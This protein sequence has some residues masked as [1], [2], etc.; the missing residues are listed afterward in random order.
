MSNRIKVTPEQIE[1]VGKQFEQGQNQSRQIVEGLTRSIEQMQS[2]WEGMTRERF[3]VQFQESRQQMSKFLECLHNVSTDLHQIATKFR[4]A[5]INNAG[6]GLALVGA[7]AVAAVGA[8]GAAATTAGRAATTTATVGQTGEKLL[9][10]STVGVS[11][12][13]GGGAPNI[14]ASLPLHKKEGSLIHHE[15]GKLSVD[16]LS[17]SSSFDNNGLKLEG[18]VVKTDFNGE[19]VDGTLTK[20][21]GS[22]EAS[23]KDGSVKL[24]AEATLTKYEGGVDIPLPFTDKKLHLGGSA[25]LG[26]VGASAEAG[27]QGFKF[28]VPLGPGASLFGLGLDVKVK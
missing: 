5:D 25:S 11:M 23:Y 21:G 27:L 6:G 3:Y 9:K 8:G 12:T 15:K 2:Q 26:T 18:A 16:A 4:E 24:G 14:T 28:H 17:G 20:M 10:D 22:L 19:Y 7:G 1:Q 13:N